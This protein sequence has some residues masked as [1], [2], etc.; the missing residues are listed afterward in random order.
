MSS[1]GSTLAVKL[2]SA[3][4]CDDAARGIYSHRLGALWLVGGASNPNP[5]PSP[6]PNP[7]PNPNRNRNPNPNPNPLP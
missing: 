2:L 5:S 3:T 1:L 6:S 4:P 7:K